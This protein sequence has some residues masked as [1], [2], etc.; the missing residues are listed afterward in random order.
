MAQPRKNVVRE[1]VISFVVNSFTIFDA[2]HANRMFVLWSIALLI[3]IAVFRPITLR[4]IRKIIPIGFKKKLPDHLIPNSPIYRVM[5][6]LHMM[7]TFVFLSSVVP[8]TRRSG[9][10]YLCYWAFM[11]QTIFCTLTMIPRYRSIRRFAMSVLFWPTNATQLMANFGY[12]YYGF[13][14]YEWDYHLVHFLPPC[15]LWTFMLV[16]IYEYDDQVNALTKG[17][18]GTFWLLISGLCV[19]TVYQ[20]YFHVVEVYENQMQYMFL[21]ASVGISTMQ[22]L[23]SIIGTIIHAIWIKKFASDEVKNFYKIHKKKIL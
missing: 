21:F 11:A 22:F 17:F 19:T 20:N 14:T 16:N 2:E 15:V 5:S 12:I 13:V 1:D 18:W 7:T 10:P 9:S 4:I 6:F 8:I 23:F 3:F